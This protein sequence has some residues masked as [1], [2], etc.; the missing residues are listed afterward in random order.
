M[1]IG[2][3]FRRQFGSQT[4]SVLLHFQPEQSGLCCAVV[5]AASTAAEPALF[6]ALLLQHDLH[7]K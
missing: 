2:Q 4:D 7:P 6:L 1:Q 3:K 5:V